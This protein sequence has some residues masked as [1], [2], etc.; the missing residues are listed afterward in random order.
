MN[1]FARAMTLVA[2]LAATGVKKEG[3]QAQEM[4]VRP[5]QAKEV[6]IPK[7]GFDSRPQF[8]KVDENKYVVQRSLFDG[9][10][11]QVIEYNDNDASGWLSAGD[12]KF[13]D[14][15]HKLVDGKTIRAMTIGETFLDDENTREDFRDST[16]YSV[17]S[18]E[19][20]A[21]LNEFER[22]KIESTQQSNDLEK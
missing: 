1:N 10:V 3:V 4:P 14:E 9:Q 6:S 18:E 5:R 17:S 11:I 16:L 2:L 22:V 20:K 8:K 19:G 12:T 15:Y 13:T 7:S 21:I